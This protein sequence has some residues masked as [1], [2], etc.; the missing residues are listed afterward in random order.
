MHM[1]PQLAESNLVGTSDARATVEADMGNSTRS[2]TNETEQDLRKTEEKKPLTL[3]DLP[4]DVLCEIIRQVSLAFCDHCDMILTLTAAPSYQRLNLLSPLPFRLSLTLCPM[5]LLSL[6]HCLAGCK[7]GHILQSWCGRSDIWPLDAGH[8][9][10][11]LSR[12]AMAETIERRASEADG[13]AC[14]TTEMHIS[15]SSTSPRQ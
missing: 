12:N 15:Y 5:Y 3:K 10:R 9:R 7:C 13:R 2:T 14:G 11:S 8:G 1:A 4:E 6:R